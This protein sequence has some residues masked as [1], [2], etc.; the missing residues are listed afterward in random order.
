MATVQLQTWPGAQC[1]AQPA[2][3]TDPNQV[4]PVMADDLG[5]VQFS[6]VRAAP[7]DPVTAVVV[8]CQDGS[9]KTQTYPLDLTSA[10]TFQPL[11][12][13]AT[14]APPGTTRPALKGDPMTYSEQ[15]LIDQG[16]GVRP[17]P[18]VAPRAY[19]T[20]RDAASKPTRMVQRKPVAMRGHGGGSTINMQPPPGWS[21]GMLFTN[22]Y[23]FSFFQFVIPTASPTTACSAAYIWGGLGGFFNADL[24]Q[25]GVQLLGNTTLMQYAPMAEYWSGNGVGGGCY[26]SECWL[27]FNVAAGDTFFGEAWACDANG[28]TNASGGFGCFFGEDTTT[29]VSMMCDTRSGTCTSLP[30]INQFVGATAEAIIEDNA[31]NNWCNASGTFAKYGS[32]YMYFMARDKNG[33]THDWATD[34]PNIVTI[35]VVNSSGQFLGQAGLSTSSSNGDGTSF[36][37]DQGS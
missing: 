11:P 28:N 35:N 30:Q 3:N 16:Y 7:S 32:A 8:D 19:Q 31:P 37:W 10:S 29:G 1:S 17:D 4:L 20:W 26:S 13:S 25:D 12:A 9:G 24:I 14:A 23:V 33:I 5:V 34:N 18:N 36:G 6:A 15:E 2:G 21:G 22:T 27:G